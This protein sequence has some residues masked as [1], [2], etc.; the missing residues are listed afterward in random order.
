MTNNPPSATR[1]ILVVDDEEDFRTVFSSVL[2]SAGYEITMAKSGEEAIEA[3]RNRT[4]DLVVLDINMPNING[5]QVLDWIRK[6]FPA[7]KV[8][9]MTG[10]YDEAHIDESLRRGADEVFGK[11]FQVGN[12]LNSVRRLLE[13]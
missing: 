6:D 12:V 13:E 1:H 8:I 7:M 3:I 11:P 2:S 9:I 5:I 10:Y 4:F